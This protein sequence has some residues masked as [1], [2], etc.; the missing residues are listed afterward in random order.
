MKAR[1]SGI[2]SETSAPR[3]SRKF[4][5]ER[6]Q[7]M[8]TLEERIGTPYAAAFTKCAK[9]V[10]IE[11]EDFRKRLDQRRIDSAKAIKPVYFVVTQG[12]TL[13]V[14]PFRFCRSAPIGTGALFGVE[15]CRPEMLYV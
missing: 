15:F 13:I 11:G 3:R 4:T 5:S 6:I 9:K 14:R 7:E 12:R 2:R 8:T 1:T 10:L